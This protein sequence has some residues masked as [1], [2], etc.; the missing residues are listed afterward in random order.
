MNNVIKQGLQEEVTAE[1]TLSQ[2]KQPVTQ[3]LEG[4]GDQTEGTECAKVLKE[5]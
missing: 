3:R 1:L 5:E 4:R 2:R